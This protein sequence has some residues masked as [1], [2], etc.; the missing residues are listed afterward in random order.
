M[1]SIHINPPPPGFWYT[2]TVKSKSSDHF[3]TVDLK[4]DP[5]GLFKHFFLETKDNLNFSGP[6]KAMDKLSIDEKAS[7]NDNLD[8]VKN[9]L[10]ELGYDFFEL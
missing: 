6:V 1:I 7:F 4:Q 3:I 9:Y 2:F 10:K 5:D 8:K